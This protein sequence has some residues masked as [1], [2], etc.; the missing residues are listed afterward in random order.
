MRRPMFP[1][2]VYAL[3]V[4]ASGAAAQSSDP[5]LAGAVLAVT[6]DVSNQRALVADDL[7]GDGLR[8]LLATSTSLQLW[9]N[10]GG[11]R[12]TPVHT[13]TGSFLPAGFVVVTDLDGDG[14][15][16]LVSVR[17][18]GLVGVELVAPFEAGPQ[19]PLSAPDDGGGFTWAASGDL[20][21][22]G[23]PDVLADNPANT[24]L[25]AWLGDGAGG[26]AP[27]VPAAAVSTR[28]FDLGDL[29]LDG[30]LDVLHGATG[31]AAV[32]LGQGDGSF[33]PQPAFFATGHDVAIGHLDGDGLPDAAVTS[34]NVAHGLALFLGNGAGGFALQS[35]V[36]G[37]AEWVDL[38]DADGDGDDDVLAAHRNVTLH[39]QDAAVVAGSSGFDGWTNLVR[40]AILA[41]LEGDG[42]PGAVTLGGSAILGF[43]TVYV[44]GDG[45]GGLG[46]EL[47]LPVAAV[48]RLLAQADVDGDGRDEIVVYQQD[49]AQVVVHEV[50]GDGTL[51][52]A[53]APTPV[54]APPA[55]PLGAFARVLDL[56]GDPFADLLFATPAGFEA[57]RSNGDGTFAPGGLIP[58]AASDAKLYLGDIDG[59]GDDDLLHSGANPVWHASLGDGTFGAAQAVF[60]ETAPKVNLALGDADG[61]GFA[62]LFAGGL[63]A[64]AGALRWWQGDGAGHFVAPQVLAAGPEDTRGVLVVDVDGDADLDVL[65]HGVGPLAGGGFAG[66]LTVV[67]G[68]GDGTFDAPRVFPAGY[69]PP[70]TPPTTVDLDRDGRREVLL[71]NGVSDHW[72]LLPQAADGSFGQER[73]LPLVFPGSFSAPYLTA[74]IDG[75]G[76]D[77]ILTHSVEPGSIAPQLVA[78][79]VD[80]RP[81]ILDLG[82]GHTNLASLPVLDGQGRLLPGRGVELSLA[83]APAGAPVLLLLG[84]GTG[85]APL[86]GGTLVPLPQVVLAGLV[87][88]AGGALSLL[89]RW[90]A[91]APPGLAAYVQAW[92]PDPD[93]GATLASNALQFEGL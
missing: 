88:D 22:D 10:V 89:S 78:S 21:G 81:G 60:I 26:L 23:A 11:G 85:Y 15:L 4:L 86:A 20:N 12:L 66:W 8:D 14:L 24:E 67:H 61:D 91:D 38:A 31:A 41:D 75:D 70:G 87:S 17:M 80:L 39:L 58:P 29:D 76:D 69:I 68:H 45:L 53:G 72:S 43:E 54:A 52:P 32:L 63:A 64:P 6:Q 51:G 82:R 46:L 77:D 3:A 74:D 79:R 93:S 59:D 42:R 50:P 71:H 62:D 7:D 92:M 90:P 2:S 47:P 5:S 55:T 27:S 35:E 28:R 30:D 1:S 83:A 16:S 37:P 65:A 56:D 34:G 19:Q 36:P 40:D 9:R 25:R 44:P 57:W 13:A 18:S 48:S 49:L 33:V 84:L 73:R